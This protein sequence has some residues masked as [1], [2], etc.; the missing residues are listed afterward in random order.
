MD[1]KAKKLF[2][3]VSS[4]DVAGIEKFINW[5]RMGLDLDIDFYLETELD[6]IKI[7]SIIV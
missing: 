7:V 3:A 6:W 1:F 4:S 2:A 5:D